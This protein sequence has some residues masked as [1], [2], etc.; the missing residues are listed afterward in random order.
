[1]FVRFDTRFLDAFTRADCSD[2]RLLR[3]SCGCL[4]IGRLDNSLDV[5]SPRR[6]L[7]GCFNSLQHCC[8]LARSL[9]LTLC[10]SLGHSGA[11][12]LQ[13]SLRSLLSRS[14]HCS[15]AASSHVEQQPQLLIAQL[16]CTVNSMVIE[17]LPAGGGVGHFVA[18][19]SRR[20][21]CSLRRGTPRG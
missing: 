12:T 13:F 8:L 5:L 3:G 6:H 2:A 14:L 11:W 19:I 18:S 21:F 1:M 20:C 17:V 9:A 10:L 15:V 4:D 7:L 16:F